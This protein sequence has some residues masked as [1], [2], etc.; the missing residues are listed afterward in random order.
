[1]SD[2][3]NGPVVDPIVIDEAYMERFTNDQ[4]AYKAWIGTDLVT[5]ILFDEEGADI[6]MQDARHEAAHAAVALRVLVRRLTGMDPDELRKA[7]QQ[8]QL[9]T[10]VL[11]PD[12]AQM[13]AWETKQ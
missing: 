6:C 11:S 10:L 7:V 13:P 2:N 8:R 9:E 3:K 4:L 12:T 1:M 5:E